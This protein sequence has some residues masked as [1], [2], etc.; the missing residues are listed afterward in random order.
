MTQLED[1]FGRQFYYLRLSITDVCNFRCTYCLPDGYRPNGRNYFITQAEVARITRA[2]AALGTQK[3]RI[4][5]GEP[6]MRKDFT[7]LLRTVADTPGITKVALTT[8]GYRLAKHAQEWRDAGLTHLNVSVDSLDP[9]M[10]HQITG[11][12]LFHEVM[13]GVDAALDA[14]FEQVKLNSV[15]L[16]GLN[17][18]ELDQFLDWIKTRPVEMRFIELMQTGEMD[19]FFERHHMS[20]EQIKQRMLQQGWQS[21][22]REKD[23]GPA[24]RFWHPDYAGKLGLIMPYSKDFCAGCNRLRVSAQG[25]LHLCLFGEGGVELRDLLAADEQQDELIAR[26]QSA[27]QTKRETHYLHQGDAGSTPHLASIGG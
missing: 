17:G 16:K 1:G 15:L 8:N 6:T 9:K 18:K 7:E 25:K 23:A 21:V 27:L 19:Q 5:G 24:E 20:G 26:L 4:T 22:L 14:G 11:E 3:V 13:A 12:N 2:F 10:F